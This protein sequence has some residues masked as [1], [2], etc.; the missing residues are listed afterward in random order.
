MDNGAH[1]GHYIANGVK[2]GVGLR[3]LVGKLPESAL[4]APSTNTLSVFNA[5]PIRCRNHV[6]D[7]NKATVK[8][9]YCKSVIERCWLHS[10]FRIAKH[11][12]DFARLREGEGIN[13]HLFFVSPVSIAAL[14]IV[15]EQGHT[16]CYS[17][18]SASITCALGCV[19][20][21]GGNRREKL[22][23][24]GKRAKLL[25]LSCLAALMK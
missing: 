8:G 1:R 12:D 2:L 14:P 4:S 17:V 22:G 3:P 18:T 13:V 16:M 9:D 21:L 5:T 24:A 10:R 25:P 19:V 15:G 11:G 23:I 20:G 7:V 6:A